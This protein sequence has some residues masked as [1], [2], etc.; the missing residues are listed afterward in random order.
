MRIS[1]ACLDKN[2]AIGAEWEAQLAKFDLPEAPRSRV[3]AI[4]SKHLDEQSCRVTQRVGGGS[5]YIFLVKAVDERQY[6][7]RFP[8]PGLIKEPVKKWE[9]EVATMRFLQER[10][11][12]PIPKLVG[13]GIAEGEFAELGPYILIEFVQGVALDL[14]LQDGARLKDTAEPDVM[15]VIYKRIAVHYVE[16]FQHSFPKIGSIS[17]KQV[18]ENGIWT[19]GVDSAPI[20][21]QMNEV[22]RGTEI[23]YKG[24]QPTRGTR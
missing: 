21:F 19:F 15:R 6:V 17:A 8:V 14:V 22:A 9:A 5:N 24:R 12:I 2:D 3:E 16:M 23:E 7:L 4:A 1:H 18:D 10:T 13:A 20:T 11:R